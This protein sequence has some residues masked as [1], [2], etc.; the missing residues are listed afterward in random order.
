MGPNGSGK[1]NVIDALL[2]VF[3]YRARK[4]RSKKLSVLIHNSE[5]HKDVAS[6]TVSIHFHKIIDMVCVR[7]HGNMKQELLLVLKLHCTAHCNRSLMDGL[8]L[9]GCPYRE[10]KLKHSKLSDVKTCL[11]FNY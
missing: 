6:C 2:F 11:C 8:M 7:S 1:S 5:G 3:G 10:Q 4:I 9:I